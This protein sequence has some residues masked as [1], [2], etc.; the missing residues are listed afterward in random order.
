M[1]YEYWEILEDLG[2]LPDGEVPAAAVASLQAKQNELSLWLIDD[3]LSNF[4]RAAI[5]IESGF[6]K[7]D[8]FG[9]ALVRAELITNLGLELRVTDGNSKDLE[10][11]RWHRDV[12][13][14][15][16]TALNLFA[17]IVWSEETTKD[18]VLQKQI[19]EWAQRGLEQRHLPKDGWSKEQS[20]Q[21]GL[22]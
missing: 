10:A 5:A 7:F 17:K 13:H 15:T 3:D 20:K 16:G 12:V 9:Y 22:S 4:E 19:I 21:L 6:S 11:N 2:W 1:K 8:N 14:L 18:I